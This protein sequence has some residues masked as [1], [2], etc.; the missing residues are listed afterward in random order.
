[1]CAVA[2]AFPDIEII[3]YVIPGRTGTQ[4][5]P[6]DLALL[7]RELGNV[8]AV[9]EATGSIENM[10]RTRE[11]CGPDFSIISGDDGITFE[12]MTDPE[13]KGAGVI[14][15]ASNIAPGAVT[16]MVRLLDQGNQ[17][18]AAK[19]ASALKPFFDLIGFKTLEKTP[20]GDVE[21][22][23]RNPLFIKTIMSILGLPSGG[24]RK[25]LGK[26]TEN[27][28][29]KVLEAARSVQANNPEILKPAAEFFGID[30]DDRLSNP[31]NWEGLF[32]TEY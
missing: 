10:K 27:G 25:P 2:R 18:E 22:R 8:N 32:Y 9:K 12:M 5:L 16:E 1:M 30:I 31:S 3:P 13:I 17:A 4:M 24:C 7:H 20:Y 19:L 26:M 23:A 21:C 14:S 11:C 28:I 15:V 6:E 29:E